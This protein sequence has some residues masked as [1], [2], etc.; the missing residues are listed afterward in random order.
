MTKI[1]CSL[2][3]P[4]CGDLLKNI[5]L[6]VRH[7]E[8]IMS[9]ICSRCNNV[10]EIYFEKVIVANSRKSDCNQKERKNYD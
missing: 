10:F 3:C 5:E 2:T 7:P 8:D 6:T 9:Y 1:R 4:Y